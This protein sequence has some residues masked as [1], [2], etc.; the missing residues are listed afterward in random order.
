MRLAL[1][2]SK[3]TTPIFM[4][5]VYFSGLPIRRCDARVGAQSPETETPGQYLLGSA[6]RR[7]RGPG[8]NEES[9]LAWPRRIRSV[10]RQRSL[11]GWQAR[12]GCG[13]PTN[14]SAADVVSR[15]SGHRNVVGAG[16]ARFFSCPPNSPEAISASDCAV[17]RFPRGYG[18]RH[19]S[20]AEKGI[21]ISVGIVKPAFQRTT[22]R[23]QHDS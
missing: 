3:V 13:T 10:L 21:G 18:F 12:T 11:L 4:G 19:A 14:S 17:G 5:V 22:C 1:V 9:I 8:K 7:R 23:D 16:I 6:Q 15:R 20:S 2:I